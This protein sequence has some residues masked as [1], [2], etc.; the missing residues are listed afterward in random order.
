MRSIWSLFF[1]LVSGTINQIKNIDI[2]KKNEKIYP[3]KKSI[4]FVNIGINKEIKKLT[5]QLVAEQRAIDS[6]LVLMGYNS[7]T[8]TNV[9]GPDVVA[10]KTI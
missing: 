7:E 3:R 10:K 5:I 9:T 6:A 2:N 1:P 8:T 4:F